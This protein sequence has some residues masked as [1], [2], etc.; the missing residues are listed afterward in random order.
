MRLA[1]PA[2]VRN[3]VKDIQPLFLV[4]PFGRLFQVKAHTFVALR[5]K[6][7]EWCGHCIKSCG[8]TSCTS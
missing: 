8:M 6:Y 3:N 5:M 4:N 2:N 7:G 1:L